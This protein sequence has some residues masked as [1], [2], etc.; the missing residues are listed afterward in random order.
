MTSIKINNSKRTIEMTKAFANAASL[1]G[2]DEYKQLQEA[3]HDYPNYRVVTLK[4]KITVKSDFPH[5]TYDFM[6]KYIANHDVSDEIASQYRNLRGQGENALG[7][8]YQIIKDWF[9][10]TFKEFE[11][12]RADRQALLEKIKSEKEAR[13][14]ARKKVA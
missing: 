2:S 9:L 7:V 3:R 12:F 8:D 10:N 5:L 6:D 14:A 11:Q 13:L 4:Q 1:F